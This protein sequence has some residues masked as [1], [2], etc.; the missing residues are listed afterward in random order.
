M[1]RKGIYGSFV[2]AVM[3]VSLLAVGCGGGSS[4]VAPA[5]TNTSIQGTITDN[6]VKGASVKLYSMETGALLDTTTSGTDGSYDLSADLTAYADADVFYIVAEDGEV[7]GEPVDFL[8]FKSIVGDNT[9]LK[10]AA[11]ADGKVTASEVPDLTVS[12]VS[13][14]KV[15]LVEK[16]TNITLS[17]TAVSTA[18][19]ATLVASE[20]EQ[21]DENLGLVVK[22]AGAIKAA[23]DHS[24]DTTKTDSF[25]NQDIDEYI[26]STIT[27]T[28]GVIEITGMDAELEAAGKDLETEILNDDDLVKSAVGNA[29]PSDFSA[30]SLAGTWYGYHVA[31]WGSNDNMGDP[32][33]V[34]IVISTSGCSTNQIQMTISGEDTPICGDLIDNVL[35]FSFASGDAGANT[36]EG[37]GKIEGNLINGTFTEKNSSGEALSGGIFKLGLD[38]S[39]DDFSGTYDFKG[40]YKEMYQSQKAKTDNVSAGGEGDIEGQIIVAANGTVSGTIQDVSDPQSQGTEQIVGEIMGPRIT[41]KISTGDGTPEDTNSLFLVFL[42]NED[43]VTGLFIEFEGDLESPEGNDTDAYSGGKF[44]LSTVTK[45]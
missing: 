8:K 35:K 26:K 28:N 3:A 1:K 45:Q 23:V 16:A 10:A 44:K 41:V 22:L 18:Q 38:S 42:I 5:S 6:I 14:A 27:T 7:N 11:L 12:N 31:T 32:G 4:S 29:G 15:A 33:L 21:E 13:T 17:G 19:V 40:A 24:T 39:S 30:S 2:A 20:K 43:E 25:A 36:L 9:S 34:D 37:I